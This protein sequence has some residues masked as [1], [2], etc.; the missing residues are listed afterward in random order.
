MKTHDS[1]I[2]KLRIF[3]I[4]SVVSAHA[5]AISESA[6][7][8]NTIA[9]A[10][11]GCIGAMGVPLFFVISGYLFAKTTNSAGKFWTSRLKSVIVPWVFCETGLWL[12]VVLRKGGMTFLNWLKF[13]MGYQST[14][15]F[16]TLLLLFYIIFWRF[17]KTSG[18]LLAACVLSAIQIICT[19]WQIQPVARFSE[20]F[21]TLYLNPFH[22]MIYFCLGILIGYYNIWDAIVKKSAEYLPVSMVCL[23]IIITMHIR[24][25]WEY[26]YFSRYAL[27]NFLL[28]STVIMGMAWWMQWY[29]WNCLD[30]VGRWS[31]SIYLL[32]QFVVGLIVY[33]TKS[34]DIWIVTLFRP[35]F[36]IFIVV[37]AIL[38]LC[39]VNETLKGKLQFCMTLIGIR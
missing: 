22:F 12:Y 21:G 36:T 7:Y 32:H 20:M 11:L 29:Q 39:K 8:S 35:V 4:F 33:L 1:Y 13:V 16:L 24:N 26:T 17:R 37:I 5:G 23:I 14:T 25:D 30:V 28:S 6:S 38:A 3:A 19:G 18:I 15:Y 34:I 2:D 10:L 9:S 31:Y 27:L